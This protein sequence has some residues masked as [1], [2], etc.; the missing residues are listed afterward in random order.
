M[1]RLMPC[2]KAG[3]PEYVDGGGLC[4]RHRLE[5]EAEKEN[6]AISKLYQ[7]RAWQ[8]RRT[9]LAL[10]VRTRNPICQKLHI[11]GLR[12]RRCHN[13]SDCVHHAHGPR[14]R[15]DLFLSVYDEHGKS[16]LIALCN[17]CHPRERAET[18]EWRE[19]A[20]GDAVPPGES[21]G[22]FFVRTQWSVRVA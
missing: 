19:M 22:E 8:S 2:R 18:S 12:L 16:N 9:G 17:D 11:E 14:V 21:K 13:K 7:L 3:C 15:P 5:A 20:E 10:A 1:S 6:D 4:A